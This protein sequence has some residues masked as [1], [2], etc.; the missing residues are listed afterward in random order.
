MFAA[1]VPK[2]H[3]AWTVLIACFVIGSAVA[4]RF[5]LESIL[6]FVSVIAAFLGR[7]ALGRYLCFSPWIMFY[8]GIFLLGGAWL[9]FGYNLRFLI[10]LGIAGL[11][12]SAF[13]LV[14]E[15]DKK[16]MTLSGQVINILGL[17]LA[18][19][20]AE[21]CASGVYSLKTLGVWLV[22]ISF[23][24]GSLFHVRF[25]VRRRLEASG[26]FME[27]LRAG[28]PSLAFHLGALLGVEVLS[29][30]RVLP[31]FAPLALA[32][33]TLKAAWPI[34]RRRPN[35]LPVKII[36]RWELVHTLIFLIVTVWV[37]RV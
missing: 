36:G 37:F 30:F 11:G 21:Y 5:G 25:L 22:C 15:K 9:V 3:G 18:A 10:P 28:L 31:L 27:R 7:G 26:E 32:P 20:A 33:V 23:F 24:L 17:S 1:T 13:S 6:L 4:P 19:P 8:S 16:D 14:L 2:Q 35:P 12:L 34:I 29:E